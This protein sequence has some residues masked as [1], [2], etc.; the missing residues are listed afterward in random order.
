M[1]RKLSWTI[2]LF[3]VLTLVSACQPH[4]D[5]GDDFDPSP[6]LSQAF[7]VIVNQENS[8]ISPIS[9]TWIYADEGTASELSVVFIFSSFHK[10]QTNAVDYAMV[11]AY[12]NKTTE[13][14]EGIF[15]DQINNDELEATTS[16]A[17]AFAE[18]YV[19][20]LTQMQ[21]DENRLV[22]EGV[23]SQTQ[24]AD[25]MALLSDTNLSM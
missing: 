9:A 21:A 7:Q 6:Y 20:I 19:A 18:L 16:S 3:V 23:F 5:V 25:A 11:T 22:L 24:I 17:Q 8:A 2:G 13:S 4:E 14:L 15:G 1:M 12:I 10:I